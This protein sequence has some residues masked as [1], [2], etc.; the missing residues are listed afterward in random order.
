MKDSKS[1]IVPL[2]PDTQ[3]E[4][5]KVLKAGGSAKVML[6]GS[7]QVF[8]MTKS[9]KGGDYELSNVASASS[10]DNM[11]NALEKIKAKMTL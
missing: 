9:E 7:D 5:D 1:T 2:E 10:N 11:R 3:V 4:L 8:I 6:K